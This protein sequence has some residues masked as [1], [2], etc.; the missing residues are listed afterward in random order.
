[1]PS[2]VLLLFQ[3]NHSSIDLHE[4]TPLGSFE[5]INN[6]RTYVSNQNKPQ[7]G[8]QNTVILITDI[9]GVDLVNAKLVADE[10]AGNGW[11]VLLPDFFENGAVPVEQLNVS[12]SYSRM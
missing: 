2:L 1:M 11:K 5:T 9:F 3:A 8:P 10:W 4:G 6:I 12:V 7:S